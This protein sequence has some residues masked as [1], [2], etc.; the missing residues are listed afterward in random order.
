M[1][2]D[3]NNNLVKSSTNNGIKYYFDEITSVGAQI[4][5]DKPKRITSNSASLV[6][7]IYIYKNDPTNLITPSI[8]VADMSDHLPI[9]VQISQPSGTE[10]SSQYIRD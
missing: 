7:H 3:A 1:Y 10:E 5:I 2:A 4:L 6:D 9:H 8:L